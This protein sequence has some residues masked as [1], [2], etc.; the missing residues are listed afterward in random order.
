MANTPTK[1]FGPKSGDM[2]NIALPGNT[3]SISSVIAAAIFGD[4]SIQDASKL[5]SLGKKSP[6]AD[7]IAE[8][9]IGSAKIYD[10]Q[11]SIDANIQIISKE[12][13]ESGKVTV[14][15]NNLSTGI[16]KLNTEVFTDGGLF[17]NSFESLKESFNTSLMSEIDTLG[18][19]LTDTNADIIDAISNKDFAEL[20]H[21]PSLVDNINNLY[22]LQNKHFT[23]NDEILSSLKDGVVNN[24]KSNDL[25]NIKESLFGFVTQQFP[26]FATSIDSRIAELVSTI[27]TMSGDITDI[28]DNSDDS[29]KIDKG[30]INDLNIKGNIIDAV[31]EASGVSQDKLFEY[32]NNNTN[33]K[34][35]VILK[36]ITNDG[37]KII[38][39]NEV[40][41]N[42]NNVNVVISSLNE[43]INEV[44]GTLKDIFKTQDKGGG[45]EDAAAKVVIALSGVDGNAMKQLK[46]LA[47][48]KLTKDSL[49]SAE[50]LESFKTYFNKLDEIFKLQ[51][52]VGASAQ[53]AAKANKHISNNLDQ[54]NEIA[55]KAE[56]HKDTLK[57]GTIS[58]EGVGNFLIKAGITM[59]IGALFMMIPGMF[60]NALKFTAALAIFITGVLAPLQIISIIGEKYGAIDTDLEKLKGLIFTSGIILMIG[61]LFMMIPGAVKNALKFTITLTMFLTSIFVPFMLLNKINGENLEK[62]L[63]GVKKIIIAASFIM[64]IGAAFIMLGGGK[65]MIAALKFGALLSAFIAM[66]LVP[67]VLYS[68]LVGESKVVLNEIKGL[69]VTAA[70][71]MSLG[72]LFVMLGGGQ[73]VIN[74]L[75]FG[76]VLSVFIGLI[77]LPILVFEMLIRKGR[78]LIDNFTD[79]VVV[80][81]IVMIVGALFMSNV[82]L[83][84]R[85]L[86][87]G[88]VL[89]T[90]IGL[91]LFPLMVFALLQKR[92]TLALI[93]V[94]ALILVSTIVLFIGAHFMKDWNTVVR[95]I[96]F[97]LLLD[98]FIWGV[99]APL[100]VYGKF[101]KGSVK[102]LAAVA[103][104]ILVAGG[105][106]MGGAYV[107]DKYG[108][109]A[110]GFAALMGA[111]M[112]EMV[113]IMKIVAR[114]NKTFTAASMALLQMSAAIAL[115]TGS[116]SLLA[117]VGDT[118]GWGNILKGA[119]VLLSF[120]GILILMFKKLNVNAKTITTG[121]IVAIELAASML[122]LS[123]AIGT[124][125][126]IGKTFGWGNVLLGAVTLLATAVI[127]TKLYIELAAME[128][129]IQ[130]SYKVILSIA[131]SLAIM[132][133][134]IGI[135]AFM[136]A[137]YGWDNVLLGV[138][139]LVVAAISFGALYCAMAK[140]DKPVKAGYKTILAIAGSLAIMSIA[141]GIIAYM[142]ATYGWE[143]V[144][145]GVLALASIAVIFGT[146]Y[147]ALSAIKKPVKSGAVVMLAIAGSLSIMS[148][149]LGL[150]VYMGATYGWEN[151][152][153]G[154]VTLASLA[155]IFGL[156]YWGLAAIGAGVAVGAAV[157]LAI[158]A[159][160]GLM[161]LV[162]WGVVALVEKYGAKTLV[163]SLETLIDFVWGLG[164][165][166][167]KCT[168]VGV[169]AILGLIGIALMTP[170]VLGISALVIA[171]GTALQA[172]R[173][174]VEGRENVIDEIKGAISSFIGIS[175]AAPGLFAFIKI[176]K[177]LGRVRSLTYLT[178]DIVKILAAAIKSFADLRIPTKWNEDGEPI[179]YRQLGPDDFKKAADSVAITMTTIASA[180]TTTYDE[181]PKLFGWNAE[182][183]LRQVRRL[184]LTEAFI[185]HVLC[186]GIKS[187]AQLMIPTKWDK[188][189]KP[190]KFRL[191]TSEDFKNAAVGVATVMTTLAEAITT[192][193]NENKWLFKSDDFYK[194]LYRVRHMAFVEGEILST[195][196]E[197]IKSYAQIMIPI[198]WNNKGVAVKYKQMTNQDF[199]DAALNISAVMRLLAFSIASIWD[200]KEY[201]L[202][203]STGNVT[204]GG[205]EGLGW[206]IFLVPYIT[207][208]LM[209]MGELISSI[210]E[211]MASYAKLV[212]PTKWDKRGR[213]TQFRQMT[214]AEFQAAGE[215]IGLVITSLA[216]AVS[217]AYDTLMPGGWWARWFG[218]SP[219]EKI[220]ALQP[221]GDLVLSMA[222]GLQGYANLRVPKK[223][224]RKGQPT[225]FFDI[226]TDKFNY[227]TIARKGNYYWTWQGSGNFFE[228][229]GENIKTVIQLLAYA[230]NNAYHALPGGADDIKELIEAFIPMGDLVSN[231]AQGLQAYANLRVPVFGAR[232]KIVSYNPMTG[233]DIV[234]AGINIGSIITLLAN[235]VNSAWTGKPFDV[236]INDTVRKITIEGGLKNSMDSEEFVEITN[237]FGNLGNMIKDIAEGLASYAALSIPIYGQGGKIVGRKNLKEADFIMAAQN[238]GTIIALLSNAINAT[239]T[240]KAFSFIIDGKFNTITPSTS[241]KDN[242]DAD[243]FG[244]IID[245][246]GKLGGLIG[247]IADGLSKYASLQ[248]PVAWG[249]D[250]KPIKYRKMS[251]KMFTDAAVNISRVITTMLLGNN[252][253]G[254]L[255]GA[256]QT[257]ED[258]GFEDKIKEIIESFKPV[259]DLLEG[260]CKGISGFAN[261]MIPDKWDKDGKPIHYMKLSSNDFKLASKNINDVCIAVVESLISVVDNNPDYFSDTADV[262]FK[263]V[264]DS[265]KGVGDII[266][267]I[268][269]G[270]NTFAKGGFPTY[271]K[272]GKIVGYTQLVKEDYEKMSSNIETVMVALIEA[273]IKAGEIIDKKSTS[274]EFTQSI[275]N[276]SKIGGI[277]KNIAEGIQAWAEMK[278]PI[279]WNSDGSAKGY[280][281]I[282]E[283]EI[284]EAKNNIIHIVT[285]FAEALCGVYSKEIG[286]TT[287][288]N[289]AEGETISTI[290]NVTSECN[291]LIKNIVEI[292]KNIADMRIPTGW[293]SDG[294]AKGY[295][296]FGKEQMEEFA[297]TLSSILTQ[298][299]KTIDDVYS[300]NKELF[301]TQFNDTVSGVVNVIES[302]NSVTSSLLS[303]MST[304]TDNS[305]Q[306]KEFFNYKSGNGKITLDNG[307][308]TSGLVTDVYYILVDLSLL[309]KK[310]TDAKIENDSTSTKDNWINM[311]N[312]FS[313]LTQTLTQIILPELYENTSTIT[314]ILTKTASKD[315]KV[316]GLNVGLFI[317]LYIL[318]SDISELFT[319][320][321]KLKT[322]LDD[323]KT[324]TIVSTLNNFNAIT[325][326]LIYD[327]VQVLFDNSGIIK[328]IFGLGIDNYTNV[329]LNVIGDIYTIISDVFTTVSYVSSIKV[330]DV[331][332]Q[333]EQLGKFIDI[334]NMLLVNIVDPINT[335]ANKFND[336]KNLSSTTGQ[337]ATGVLNDMYNIVSDVNKFMDSLSGTQKFSFKGL[338][339]SI[340]VDK[341]ETTLNNFA[342]IFRLVA[343][344]IFNPLKKHSDGFT[345][346]FGY[347]SLS[348]IN[349]DK[350]DF[351]V[352]ILS[353]TFTIVTD[354]D[355]MLKHFGDLDNEI[356]IDDLITNIEVFGTLMNKLM[357]GI[358]VPLSNTYNA[359]ESL[360]GYKL[361]TDKN[362]EL[363]TIKA[364]GNIYNIIY[365][366]NTLSEKL[367]N[368]NK[369]LLNIAVNKIII[370]EI[371]KLLSKLKSE[372]ID[373][374]ISYSDSI[375]TLYNIP[376]VYEGNN[377]FN[378]AV[379]ND[380]YCVLNDVNT[381][382]TLIDSKMPNG[383]G[384][385]GDQLTNLS[386]GLYDIAIALNKF[387]SIEKFKNAIDEVNKFI[388]N[389]VNEI[390]TEKID[391]LISL[392][393][394]LNNLADKTTNLDELTNAIADNLTV[395]LDNLVT[396]MDESKL[397]IQKSEEIQQKRH[398]L[399]TQIIKEMRNVM[400]K[401]IEV[402]ISVNDSSS[403]G[404]D[405]DASTTQ[406]TKPIG[407]GADGPGGTGTAGAVGA[408]AGAGAGAVTT[409]KQGT[410]KGS[411]SG[412]SNT[413]LNEISAELQRLNTNVQ[414]LCNK[415]SVTP[416]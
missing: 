25:S 43:K 144:L 357:K 415:L 151:V 377:G 118:Y 256:Y 16:D 408:G 315:L 227:Y 136:G 298:L 196:S 83:V 281:R 2:Q 324:D 397:V 20:T 221:L 399:I 105:I 35:D 88:L 376:G 152:I 65:F 102:S 333:I 309:Y 60:K 361:L 366:I 367:T 211:G 337:M 246:F 395:A 276:V 303:V 176:K 233:N 240:G 75:A 6:I 168:L 271:D 219:D 344:N 180:I 343:Q 284:T 411:T 166:F 49:L 414:S 104:L 188:E 109:A 265:V 42:I 37:V 116:I 97:T 308:V 10:K 379:I 40:S 286:N 200:G 89:A 193:Y 392:T 57:K 114:H 223:Y 290:L 300:Q 192:T 21:I 54:T 178:S 335:N 225:E 220:K 280:K 237:A 26:T 162:V 384:N 251:D 7:N 257:I 317:D 100:I 285:S 253:E 327:V 359:V 316:E 148:L 267:N 261:L 410:D 207:K 277:I 131:G 311:L 283:T 164:E 287:F 94:T 332:E 386:N 347:K 15:L 146:L 248:V 230:V 258:L 99:I 282:T 22:K 74:A 270:V 405:G 346:V 381:L 295:E 145:T 374:V 120:I 110:L 345:T 72:A 82:K 371:S 3:D 214:N 132:S 103:L 293:Y 263:N 52:K 1:K 123:V 382:V 4:S 101:F 245:T 173:K 45:S 135:I 250:G 124:M 172:Y 358:V 153:Y 314:N 90:F 241:L 24:D 140:I 66:V 119:G 108:W 169:S 403:P 407:G 181:N 235:A 338:F 307:T 310:I 272:E 39:P 50:A 391:R 111:F 352:D 341:V 113:A 364:F 28:E 275:D 194:I 264:V 375:N 174:G 9:V 289:F 95:A 326:S 302:V 313:E 218:A 187:Y 58:M 216:K 51:T 157:L 133:V 150:I 48:I 142:G 319:L 274:E 62:Q 171:M 156:L 93:G 85:A 208:A 182:W 325:E 273:V 184:T 305:K 121:N 73:F 155:A 128:K 401:Q 86:A 154:V 232:G 330:V 199:V 33:Q 11:E 186:E 201:T 209:P 202:T 262:S 266:K 412:V 31:K 312:N 387:G 304:Y 46:E 236:T 29:V 30:F 5:A 122:I 416:R 205:G 170:A 17:T 96:A 81:T 329:K 175:D 318:Y 373:K 322:D 204:V 369:S 354:V 348:N 217:S 306:I 288:K 19:T 404:G 183:I 342:D 244:E 254:G 215:N 161:T 68:K 363:F 61:S 78:K 339:K 112:Y 18:S 87:F 353:D 378:T 195:L 365:D 165:L 67:I 372:I 279:E 323:T 12:F 400:S 130:S 355:K 231:M 268:A 351:N 191:M 92:A 158:A 38:I 106:L 64:S 239:W 44:A 255:I 389:T 80:C 27:G 370:E 177:K 138:G 388:K 125:A 296:K 69:I 320:I 189:G 117:I 413:K 137:T 292:I 224:N 98:L 334:T 409:K 393:A 210:S 321:S 398:E 55:I 185:L 328:S 234:N 249:T 222:Q 402:V 291:T 76:M 247:S 23:K 360:Y 32:L 385:Y 238:I 160:L 383:M 159:S 63:D 269:E 350:N 340:N 70:A 107:M 198:K 13:S 206:F 242:F 126:L 129:P 84:V 47:G 229:A 139:S 406:Q 127:F 336:F 396:R 226:S 179:K 77:L 301:S 259:G 36:G 212:I 14:S 390:D 299:P 394:S 203:T 252:N 41:S 197:G 79:L 53:Q 278:M 91:I 71:V 356:S 59:V 260:M 362:S 163:T 380:I 8:L 141:V 115:I 349:N 228:A 294:S 134:A 213:P 297:K 149:A 34:L 368:N 190:V 167:L 56:K 243:E 147:W 331:N 143:S